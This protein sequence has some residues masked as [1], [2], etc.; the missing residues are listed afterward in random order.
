MSEYQIKG[1]FLCWLAL[2]VVGLVMHLDQRT[3]SE[4]IAYQFIFAIWVVEVI[5]LLTVGIGSAV[6]TF[7]NRHEKIKNKPLLPEKLPTP[8]ANE[9]I[10]SPNEKELKPIPEPPP[11][12]EPTPQE[13]KQKA[14]AQILKR[15]NVDTNTSKRSGS[16]VRTL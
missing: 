9:K 2:H 15:R 11:I 6:Y 4:S 14:I 16:D 8:S 13:I 1:L 5:I 7:I 3:Y 10:E 12:L